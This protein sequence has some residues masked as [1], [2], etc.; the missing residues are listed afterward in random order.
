[1]RGLAHLRS[2]H[3][4]C[5]VLASPQFGDAGGVDVKADDLALLAKFDRQGQANI[6]QA[7]HGNGGVIQGRHRKLLV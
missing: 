3:L 6:P 5:I 4:K 2:I 1:M 7:D